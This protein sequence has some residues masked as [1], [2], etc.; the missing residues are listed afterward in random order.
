MINMKKN[1]I[2]KNVRWCFL[3][4]IE[5]KYFSNNRFL[6]SYR[7]V[8]KTFYVTIIQNEIICCYLLFYE[9]NFN[10][11]KIVFKIIITVKNR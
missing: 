9:F 10:R 4:W 5:Y 11:I 8:S 2:I 3:L 6:K 1:I 7:N